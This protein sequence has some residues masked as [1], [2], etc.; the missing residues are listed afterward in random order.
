[1]LKSSEQVRDRVLVISINEPRLEANNAPLF[2]QILLDRIEDGYQQ[3]VIDLRN[4][5]FIDSSALGAMISA[6][7]RMAAL[8][9]ITL[10]APNAAISRLLELTRMSKVFPITQTVDEAVLRHAG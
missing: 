6:V 5:Q 2:R 4:V 3:I 1:M 10:A 8:G 9:S 7:K